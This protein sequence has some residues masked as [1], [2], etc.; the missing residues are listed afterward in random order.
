[1]EDN[2]TKFLS[3]HNTPFAMHF[4]EEQLREFSES[5]DITYLKHSDV[6]YKAGKSANKMYIVGNGV[7]Q[8]TQDSPDSAGAFT[9][10]K[11]PG[12]FFGESA[13]TRAKT[14]TAFRIGTAIA[15]EE[16]TCLLGI[17]RSTLYKVFK[18][19]PEWKRRILSIIGR[20]METYLSEIPFLAKADPKEL[21]LLGSVLHYVVLKKRRTLFEEGSI[22]RSLYI[23]CKGAVDAV[24]ERDGETIILTH[25]PKGSFFGE[26]GLMIDM[27]RTAS[28]VATEDC[29][30]LELAKKDVTS[31]MEIAPSTSEHFDKITKERISTS[32][33][34]YNVSNRLKCKTSDICFRFHS[35]SQS[36][37]T[38]TVFSQNCVR[39]RNAT[40][41]K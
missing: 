25:I 7:V 4:G 35:L 13:V 40:R 3:V 11:R 30:L 24:T 14:E 32:F 20:K 21:T 1:M 17:D 2:E 36:L 10:L 29:L 37:W 15:Y 12:D 5:F 38:S 39:L 41:M 26:I 8:I 28:I 22:G 18:A 6:I 33:Q 34:K 19:H 9:Y 31:F 27:P 16:D 23:I